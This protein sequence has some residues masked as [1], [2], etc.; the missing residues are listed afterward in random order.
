MATNGKIDS[1]YDFTGKGLGELES[2]LEAWLK[3]ALKGELGAP[4]GSNTG[5]F[6]NKTPQIGHF[7]ELKT[8]TGNIEINAGNTG[9]GGA[10]TGHFLQL[11]SQGDAMV[12]AAGGAQLVGGGDVDIRADFGHVRIVAGNDGLVLED[13]PTVDPV[14]PNAIWSDDGVLVFSGHSV[15]GGTTPGGGIDFGID[16]QAGDW[17]LVQTIGRRPTGNPGIELFDN[18]SGSGPG[19]LIHGA[20]DVAINAGSELSLDAAS[21]LHLSGNDMI[22]SISDLVAQLTSAIWNSSGNYTINL[23]AAPDSFE[24]QTAG[25][26][27][28]RVGDVS[29]GKIQM[30]NLPTADPGVT[31]AIWADHGVLVKSGSTVTQARPQTL[32]T[33]SFAGPRIVANG[34]LPWRVPAP[35][36]LQSVL[37]DLGA[38]PGGSGLGVRVMRSVGGGAPTSIGSV[39]IGAG[40]TSNSFVPTVTA[41]NAN[42]RI[43]VD[44]T[45]V[46]SSSPGSD[47]VV[48][49]YGKWN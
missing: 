34:T 4:A 38:A 41:I 42:D 30:P 1:I 18:S 14:S 9:G 21:N 26:P 47:L 39:V 48:Q 36:T 25:V 24:V 20:G 7:L 10:V 17:L 28:L 33:F 11:W 43:T 8:D 22:L 16:P 44:V 45:G 31:N 19:I 12:F 27:Y 37:V 40:G 29:A 23:L 49:F 13:I 46:G 35:I 32:Q 2:W 6:F 15:P 3:G 5:L